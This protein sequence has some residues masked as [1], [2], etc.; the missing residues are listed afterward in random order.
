MNKS[1]TRA[2]R[3][4]GS[5]TTLRDNIGEAIVA[6]AVLEQTERALSQRWEADELSRVRETL[7]QIRSWLR[8]ARTERSGP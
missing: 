3:T 6:Q 7:D 4:E 1:A 5:G 8:S 2:H